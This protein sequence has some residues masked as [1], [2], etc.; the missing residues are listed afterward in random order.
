MMKGATGANVQAQFSVATRLKGVL[1][2][3]EISALQ[4]GMLDDLMDGPNYIE[5]MTCYVQLK[6]KGELYA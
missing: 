2:E 6:K 3:E 1:E 4:S 5:Y